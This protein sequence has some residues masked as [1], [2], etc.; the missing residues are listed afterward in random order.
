MAQGST[1]VM[2]IMKAAMWAAEA[3]F[4]GMFGELN[5]FICPP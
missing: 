1:R 5:R 2:L 4:Y 3:P